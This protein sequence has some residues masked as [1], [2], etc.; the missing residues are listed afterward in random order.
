MTD[1]LR[2]AAKALADIVMQQCGG[3]LSGPG[4]EAAEKARALSAALA[5]PPEQ[6]GARL[7]AEARVGHCTF[8]VGVPERMVVE[9]AKRAAQHPQGDVDK[10]AAKAFQAIITEHAERAAFLDAHP[11]V[12]QELCDL[13]E[14]NERLREA[15]ATPSPSAPL[16]QQRGQEARRIE[17]AYREGF[18]DAATFKDVEPAWRLSVSAQLAA[19]PPQAPPAAPSLEQGEPLFWVLREQLEA[20]ETTCT[21]RIWF[22]NPVNSA[23]VPVYGASQ[24]AAPV[25]LP[26]SQEPK[27]TVN[28]SA[29][30]NRAS[31]EEIPGDEPAFI[32]RARDVHAVYALK[33]YAAQCGETAHALVVADRIADFERFA[34]RYPERMKAPDTALPDQ[35][36]A[37]P[38]E[39]G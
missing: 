17:S 24:P 22:S 32:F 7:T 20:R 2:E 26:W 38:G 10:E 1:K 37:G 15:L 27:Y 34:A 23:W 21:G 35:Q 11:A 19:Q 9:A 30:V 28:G 31:G 29:I 5:S 36:A 25:G 4:F 12:S 16:D 18:N 3:Y 39:R 14:E 8:G 33:A 13:I 6:A